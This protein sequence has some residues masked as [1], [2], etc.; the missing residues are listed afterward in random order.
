MNSPRRRIS[1]V[2]S[3]RV[4]D[5]TLQALGNIDWHGFAFWEIFQM[6]S[7]VCPSVSPKTAGTAFPT[8]LYCCAFVPS[9]TQSS[10]K[11]CSSSCTTK[12]A[13][14]AG[15]QVYSRATG[16]LNDLSSNQPNL[17]RSRC[18]VANAAICRAMRLNSAG[19]RP[20]ASSKTPTDEIPN[21]WP[22]FI[23]L[24]LGAIA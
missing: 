6:C 20:F 7:I 13:H 24:M 11:P 5:V 22:N 17:A 8:C 21:I 18:F 14:I 19:S 23:W 1:S 12:Q 2:I 3:F 16:T 15:H 9:T 10:G 4:V